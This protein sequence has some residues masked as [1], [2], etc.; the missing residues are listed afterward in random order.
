MHFSVSFFSTTGS[1]HGAAVL[2]CLYHKKRRHPQKR[3][4]FAF[5]WVARLLGETPKIAKGSF[6]FP[7]AHKRIQQKDRLVEKGINFT[8]RNQRADHL[9]CRCAFVGPK[10]FHVLKLKRVLCLYIY[11]YIY[12]YTNI[13]SAF[14]KFVVW[15]GGCTRYKNQGFKSKSKPPI[16]STWGIPGVIR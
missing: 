12:I 3:H 9:V 15:I 4:P 11:I 8:T 7:L 10:T 2:V 6:G 1:Q 5:Q 13:L 14:Y 16:Q